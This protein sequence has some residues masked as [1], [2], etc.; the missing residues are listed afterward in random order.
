MVLADELVLY[1]CTREALRVF[2]HVLS[3]KKVVFI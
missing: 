3:K 2:L 1:E